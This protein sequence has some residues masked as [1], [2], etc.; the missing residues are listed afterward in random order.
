MMCIVDDV[1]AL[2]LAFGKVRTDIVVGRVDVYRLRL[3]RS[4]S[5][6]NYDTYP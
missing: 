4:I 5:K 1:M 2:R 6:S 3:E